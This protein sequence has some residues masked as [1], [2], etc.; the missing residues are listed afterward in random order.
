[1]MEMENYNIP[2]SRVLL[3]ELIV[4]KLLKIAYYGTQKFTALST[5]GHHSF[6]SWA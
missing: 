5:K 6:L 2:N 3:Q 1:M 4:V